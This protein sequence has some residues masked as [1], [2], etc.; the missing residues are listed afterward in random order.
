MVHFFVPLHG[1][2]PREAFRRTS[3]HLNSVKF[4]CILLYRNSPYQSDLPW[5]NHRPSNFIFT[6]FDGVLCSS[7]SLI[8]GVSLLTLHIVAA[9]YLHY[10]LRAQIWDPTSAL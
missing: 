5:L 3:L 8:P 6:E 4:N 1:K 2:I 9:L 10:L 7:T